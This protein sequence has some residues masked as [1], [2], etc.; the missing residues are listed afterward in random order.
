MYMQGSGPTGQQRRYH[1]IILL[2]YH[3]NA[4][5]CSMVMSGIRKHMQTTHQVNCPADELG[6]MHENLRNGNLQALRLLCSED[7]YLVIEE[8]PEGHRYMIA[9]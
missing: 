9:W 6:Q 2:R 8:L 7:L 5:A 4:D 1:R 3:T